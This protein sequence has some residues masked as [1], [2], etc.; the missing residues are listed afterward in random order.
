M[1]GYYEKT[2]SNQSDFLDWGG[3]RRV[4][5]DILR[6]AFTDMSNALGINIPSSS[7]VFHYRPGTFQDAKNSPDTGYD[8]IVSDSVSYSKD[9]WFPHGGTGVQAYFWNNQS[10]SGT[11]ALTRVDSDVNNSWGGGGPGSPIGNDNF[12]CRWVGY[13]LIPTSGTYRFG[14]VTDDGARLWINGTQVVNDWH[15]HGDT[16]NE[17]GDYT[18][19]AGDFV[20][21]TFE[22]Y[23]N[24]GGAVAKLMWKGPPNSGSATAIPGSNLFQGLSAVYV[25]PGQT[26]DNFQFL[27]EGTEAAYPVP[28][29]PDGVFD[30]V[31]FTCW[32]NL[33]AKLGT[34][35][36][37]G[38]YF[39]PD[40]GSTS[41][42]VA[43]VAMFQV[44]VTGTGDEDESTLFMAMQ[45]RDYGTSEA[46]FYNEAKFTGTALNRHL[47]FHQFF[48]RTST[49]KNWHGRVFVDGIFCGEMTARLDAGYSWYA[50]SSIAAIRTSMLAFQPP[51]MFAMSRLVPPWSPD[52]TPDFKFAWDDFMDE[53]ILAH[54]HP[55]LDDSDNP[56]T[57][58]PWGV[59]DNAFYPTRHPS[60]MVSDP[61][62]S[63][64]VTYS[65]VMDGGQGDGSTISHV[66]ITWDTPS[67]SAGQTVAVSVRASGTSFTADDAGIGWSDWVI[68]P[69]S[70]SG[71]SVAI[72]SSTR[73]SYV[74][75]R[76]R[77]YPSDDAT[78]TVSPE[79]SSVTIRAEF[80]DYTH[81]TTGLPAQF[82]LRPYCRLPA[83]YSAI[84]PKAMGLPARY[85]A[86]YSQSPV[87]IDAQYTCFH[88]ISVQIPAQY[89]QGKF[90]SWLPAQYTL[91]VPRYSVGLPAQYFL[92]TKRVRLPA[93]FHSTF[94]KGLP[95]RYTA[96]HWRLPAQ[97]R[98]IKKMTKRLPARYT[99]TPEAPGPVDPVTAT[100]PAAT[101]QTQSVVTFSWMRGSYEVDPIVAYY[102]KVARDMEVADQT[103]SN[104]TTQAVTV[105]LSQP[106]Y[107]GG[108]WYFCV[109]ARNAGGIFGPTSY[110]Q[111]RYDHPPGAPGISFMRV[112]GA[113]SV[114]TQP[115]VPSR[116]SLTLTWSPASDLDGNPLTYTV[117]VAYQ[118]DFANDPLTSQTS[119]AI[120]T[121]GINSGSLV[122]D[123]LPKK[124][125]WYWRVRANDGSQDGPWSQIGSFRLN[126]PPTKPAIIS[127]AQV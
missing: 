119:V 12:S 98:L 112:N 85:R 62:G 9:G 57:S 59:G 102:W 30:S 28:P 46:F 108:I 60:P 58:T 93:Q 67:P 27:Y 41:L 25:T 109:A 2:W 4:S 53:I 84:T 127:V 13:I 45:T 63:Q 107:G 64:F 71:T 18:L 7:K 97:F 117:Q 96:T 29:A 124:G 104:R 83:Q 23:E 31:V 72:G 36:L 114:G 19:A 68:I 24:A 61:L 10:L 94:R 5:G 35:T 54:T 113:D 106:G 51:S 81:V 92:S 56:I 77:L 75:I 44:G 21:F 82:T 47:L 86:T 1:P 87:R 11:P 43:D 69:H 39:T 80:V 26:V 48:T 14:T 100:I 125:V 76:L 32:V 52:G 73:G 17:S 37:M 38:G 115:L 40:P 22:Q 16:Y 90:R 3:S 118:E 99:A 101:W 15:D 34:R 78:C 6:L 123:T 50:N 20:S 105:D 55:L 42:S 111:V 91:Y 103:W 120:S 89:S 116:S 122:L 79:I 74:Q 8:A 70:N 110:Y 126:Q 121:S 65:P 33:I 49:Q 88:H 95:A 66:T